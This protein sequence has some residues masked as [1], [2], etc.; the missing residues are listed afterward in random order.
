MPHIASMEPTDRSM[1]AV[2]MTN[3][4]PA[5]MIPFAAELLRT[6]LKFWN[7]RN[8]SGSRNVHSEMMKSNDENGSNC[9]ASLFI[10][11]DLYIWILLLLMVCHTAA[12]CMTSSALV[13]E[14]FKS[15]V[16]RP[17]RMTNTRSHM[18][19]I[20]GSSE[21]ISRMALPAA[22]RSLSNA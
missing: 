1:P 14:T 2:M 20:S 11:A 16:R 21:E 13:S 22:A 4:I 3:V 15:A 6:F 10:M 9:L 18:P 8:V 19:R 17:S 7:V 5:A 12:L